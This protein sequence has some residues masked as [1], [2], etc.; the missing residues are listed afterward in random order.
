MGETPAPTGPDFARGVAIADVP[1]GGILAG[2]VGQEPVLL[3][4]IEDGFFAVSGACT[5]Y[6]AALAEGLIDGDTV[7]CPLHHA[8]FSLRTGTALHAPAFESL[9]RWRV[10]RDGNRLF[11]RTRLER[12]PTSPQPLHGDICDVLIVGGGAAGYA[13]A[14]RLRRL[15][16]GGVI[17]MVSAD[18]DP[19]CDRPNL[20]KDYLAGTAPDD[21]IPLRP[22]G[23]Y[24][25]RSIDLHLGT[26]IASIDTIARTAVSRQG[27]RFRFD[28][29][30]LATGSE[31]LRLDQP[32]LARENVHV[33]RSL[34]DARALAARADP[35]THVAII[36]SSFIALEAAAALRNRGV[37]VAIVS[38]DSVPFERS[39]GR[40]VG[41]FLQQLHERNGVRF[42]LESNVRDYDGATLT[43]EDGRRIVADFLLLGI[44]VTPR[45]AL[46]AATGL[47]VGDGV[48][49][50]ARLESSVP[51]I[52]AAGDIASYPDPLGEGRV[53]I[54]HWAT[55]QRQGQTAAANML[56]ARTRFEA[57]PFFWTE[58]Y[59]VALRYVGRAVRTNDVRI[60]GDLAGGDFIARY[61]D[62][63]R[64]RATA[65]IGRDR[66][67]L[68]DELRIE[69]GGD[70]ADNEPREP[71]SPDGI[72]S[73]ASGEAA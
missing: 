59:G 69:R 60:D 26:M 20:S 23:W 4:R 32:G 41:G 13:C 71:N 16:Y 22:Q 1:A 45:T 12:A 24:H 42:H 40:E 62:H 66:A 73:R 36:G 65:A 58:Q 17:T 38:R 39:L 64:L 53:R 52:Y 72:Q 19:P 6:G 57:V 68:E 21:W 3:S 8:C 54:E 49:V 15:G 27:E 9:Q 18:A 29:L 55:A 35:G 25:E 48:E 47:A 10:D 44:G 51:G 2:R 61:H 34:A 30:L 43:L 14:D 56:G 37:E 31:P 33:L 50:D 67:V 70:E 46:A 28:R 5:H 63:G 11:V 7:R